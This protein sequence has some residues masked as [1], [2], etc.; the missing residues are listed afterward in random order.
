[1]SVALLIFLAAL[2]PFVAAVSAKFG[3]DG[4]TNH[5]P[6]G[7]LAKQSGW[8]GRANAA[9]TNTFEALPLF[10]AALLYAH[11]SGVEP[12]LIHWYGVAWL[13]FRLAY[14]VAY[15]KDKASLRSLLWAISFAI[16]GLLLFSVKAI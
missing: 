4:F 7:W 1:M 14:I 10:Y 2:L 5:E 11:F 9:Q 6:R 3:G 12:E 8:R 13:V 16:N 15:I